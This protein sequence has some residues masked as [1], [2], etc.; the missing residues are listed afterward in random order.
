MGWNFCFNPQKFHLEPLLCHAALKEPSLL[1][2]TWLR[3]AALTTFSALHLAPGCAALV[4]APYART[5]A[6]CP[7]RCL[8]RSALHWKASA[9][10]ME[11]RQ[12][13]TVLRTH[14]TMPRTSSPTGMEVRRA[15]GCAS[16]AN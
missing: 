9:S 14:R 12:I 11:L 13:P 16:V 15:A 2:V 7:A 3:I 8:M 6:A 4:S 1:C 10:R 5:C